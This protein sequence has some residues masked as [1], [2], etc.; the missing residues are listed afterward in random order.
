MF[1]VSD[2]MIRTIRYFLS[3]CCVVALFF[4]SPVP[5]G[6]GQAEGPAP[7]VIR[8]TAK[9]PGQTALAPQ[10]TLLEP[11]LPIVDISGKQFVEFRWEPKTSPYRVW[12]YVFRLYRGYEMTPVRQLYAREVAALTAAIA[13]SINY[14]KDGESY[15]W[16]VVQVDAGP[17]FSDPAC[18]TFRVVK[19]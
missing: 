6:T 2:E 1:S 15:T 17:L 18:G 19:K 8:H 7:A 4:V 16:S 12:Y 14:F 10:P 11:T 13:I 3:V 5:C 9:L